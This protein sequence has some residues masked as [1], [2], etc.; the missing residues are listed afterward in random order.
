MKV[1]PKFVVFSR[2][3]NPLLVIIRTIF[4]IDVS[5]CCFWSVFF[6]ALYLFYI[7]FS[8]T[9]IIFLQLSRY[10]FFVI[11]HPDL[12]IVR[13]KFVVFAVEYPVFVA[14]RFKAKSL[15]GAAV[16][17]SRAFPALVPKSPGVLP[18][19]RSRR[20]KVWNPFFCRSWGVVCPR[21]YVARPRHLA[22]PKVGRPLA[23]TV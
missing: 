9:Y 14:F 21:S 2:F 5:S 8:T 16:S 20:G 12:V 3:C 17:R 15:V 10:L 18:G 23:R 19:P 13:P 7:L 11:V 22:P 4:A 6:K 1:S